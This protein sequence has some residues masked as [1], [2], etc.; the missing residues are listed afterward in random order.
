METVYDWL[1]VFI[2]AALVT[3][4]LQAS[5]GPREGN[6]S[7]WHYLIPSVGCAGANWLGNSGWHAAAIATIT[8]SIAYILIFLLHVGR[9]RG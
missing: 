7:V 8:V 4:F 3:R 1:T 6:E 5:A 9:P 2:F